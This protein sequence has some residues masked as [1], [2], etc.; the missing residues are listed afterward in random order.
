MPAINLYFKNK[1]ICIVK[2]GLHAGSH[3]PHPQD[4]LI[5]KTLKP[6]VNVSIVTDYT[7]RANEDFITCPKYHVVKSS[8]GFLNILTLSRAHT[9]RSWPSW[10]SSRGIVLGGTGAL[11]FYLLIL[12]FLG[13]DEGTVAGSSAGTSGW[14]PVA[15]FLMLS[16]RM[17]SW[18]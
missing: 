1:W 14:Q 6:N 5:H 8:L 16:M 7:L 10:L 17:L 12:F 2:F 4:T 9:T 11:Y 13:M 3:V 15:I 18:T